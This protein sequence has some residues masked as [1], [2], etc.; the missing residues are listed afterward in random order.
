MW[1][2]KILMG[3][4]GLIISALWG[5]QL[6]KHNDITILKNGFQTQGIGVICQRLD[7][8]RQSWSFITPS[9]EGKSNKRIKTDLNNSNNNIK[10]QNLQSNHKYHYKNISIPCFLLLISTLFNFD[11]YSR[12]R[13]INQNQFWKNVF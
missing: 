13:E 6:S 8:L 12:V 2:F 1:I 10:R 5:S 4:S 9:A 11:A 7:H 3:C